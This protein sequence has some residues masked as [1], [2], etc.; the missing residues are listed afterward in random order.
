[1]Q[2]EVVLSFIRQAFLF[3]GGILVGQGVLTSGQLELLSGAVITIVPAVWGLFSKWQDQQ[4]IQKLLDDK[5]VLKSENKD[6]KQGFTSN[7]GN[8]PPGGYGV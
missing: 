7:V 8:P 3:G 4:K 2:I 6:L 5:A 1:M